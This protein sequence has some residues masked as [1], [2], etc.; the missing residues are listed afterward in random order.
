MVLLDVA[1]TLAWAEPV[2]ALRAGLAQHAAAEELE[3]L[4]SKFAVPRDRFDRQRLPALAARLQRKSGAG[5][6]IGRIEIPSIDTDKVVVEG[7]DTDTLR[8]GPGRYPETVLPGEH[9]TVGI[10]GHR[11]TYGAPF[12]R[13]D[14]IEHG[15][16][17]VLDMPYAR[18]T[19]RFE[20]SRIVEPSQTGVVR[21]V[22]HENRV[23]LTACHPLYSAAQRYVVFARLTAIRPP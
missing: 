19:Y 12:R 18:F 5:D 14:E 8:E 17:I 16:E 9:G 1:V 15:D 13:I 6:A 7:T 11:T 20:R 4:D 21:Q 23:V 3:G 22:A 2:S 10:A